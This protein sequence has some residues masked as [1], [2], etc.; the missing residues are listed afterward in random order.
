MIVS[1]FQ[2]AGESSGFRSSA[3][4]DYILPF[5][6]RW[7]REERDIQVKKFIEFLMNHPVLYWIGGAIMGAIVAPLTGFNPMV[8]AFFGFLGALASMVI[9]VIGGADFSKLRRK[10]SFPKRNPR[11]GGGFKRF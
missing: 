7:I 8:G 4:T 10:W 11:S 6:V 9:L 5:T 3:H 2:V 1:S